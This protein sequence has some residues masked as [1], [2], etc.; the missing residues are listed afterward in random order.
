MRLPY[1]LVFSGEDYYPAGGA[2]DCD[3][4]H[5]TLEAAIKDA[6]SRASGRY[7]WAHVA[8]LDDADGLYIVWTPGIAE[9]EA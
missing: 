2:A 6:E 9:T 7:Q 5:T 3:S 4:V 1:F 8:Q